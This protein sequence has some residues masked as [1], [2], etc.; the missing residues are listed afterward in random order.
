MTKFK[1]RFSGPK[2]YEEAVEHAEALGFEPTNFTLV[3]TW[4][5]E[6]QTT[7]VRHWPQAPEK[8]GSKYF[9]VRMQ[10]DD[11]DRTLWRFEPAE[12]PSDTFRDGELLV[13]FSD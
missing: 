4:N 6:G 9:Y 13:E 3:G 7:F 5:A 8:T 1:R 2:E 10:I 11:W 12:A